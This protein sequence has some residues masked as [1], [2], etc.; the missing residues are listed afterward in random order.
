MGNGHTIYNDESIEIR[1]AVREASAIDDGLRHVYEALCE[2]GY[3][4]IKQII[5]FIL[6]QDPTYITNHNNARV[7]A[8][9]LD[10]DEILELLLKNYFSNT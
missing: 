8:S 1:K 4:P 3:D 5:G 2:R 10:R 7:I 9:R 6:S